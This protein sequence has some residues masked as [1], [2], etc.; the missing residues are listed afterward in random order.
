LPANASKTS[1]GHLRI[2][3]KPPKASTG[4][5]PLARK[6]PKGLHT[7]GNRSS[8]TSVREQRQRVEACGA[9]PHAS[10]AETHVSAMERRCRTSLVDRHLTVSL[11]ISGCCLPAPA[12]RKTQSPSGIRGESVW[13]AVCERLETRLRPNADDRFGGRATLGTLLTIAPR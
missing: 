13:H 8:L 5:L 11:T 10:D 9:T 7:G 4:H 2:A 1:T 6:S 12:E 3:G